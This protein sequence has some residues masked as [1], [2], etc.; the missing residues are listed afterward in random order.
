MELRGLGYVGVN[1]TNVDAWTPFAAD[2]FGFQAVDG[3]PGASDAAP[4]TRYFKL[5]AHS[6]R[7]AVHPSD[8]DGC[9]YVGW[10]LADA[11]S[12]DGAVA[13]VEGCGASVKVLDG[14]DRVARGVHALAR[15]DDP[16][17]NTHELFYGPHT[18]EF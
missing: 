4:G 9:A 3:P 5:D 13:S 14:P 12:F 10:E 2:V 17:G 15:F 11:A 1:A 7:F 18:D 16:F 6:W 8:A